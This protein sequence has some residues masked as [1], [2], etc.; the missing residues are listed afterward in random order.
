MDGFILPSHGEGWGLPLIEAMAS[1]L[2]TI[3]TAWGGQMDFMSRENSW[4]VS[5]SLMNMLE[6]GM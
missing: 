6:N 4:P 5:R 2:P 3:A 1:G